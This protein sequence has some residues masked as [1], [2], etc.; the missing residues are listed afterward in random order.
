MRT[1][2]HG[3]GCIGFGV[4]WQAKKRIGYVRAIGI[5]LSVRAMTPQSSPLKGEDAAKRQLKAAL[6][7]R[8]SNDNAQRAMSIGRR[9]A[10]ARLC[11]PGG[12]WDRSRA[13]AD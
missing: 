4:M 5:R 2:V 3:G 8:G 12:S 11:A 7:P 1:E 9:L 6:V 10:L 13:H